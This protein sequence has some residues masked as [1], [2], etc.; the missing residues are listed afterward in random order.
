MLAAGLE[1]IEK[2][3]KLP[4]PSK[5]DFYQDNKGVR[6]LPGDLSCALDYMNGSQ[7]LRRRLGN[8][9]VDTLYT[10]GSAMSRDYSQRVSDV[11]VE[12]FF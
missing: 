1:G 6:E 8:F 2:N 9:V 12:M 11:D 5:Q 7:M 10:L 4:P 3:S